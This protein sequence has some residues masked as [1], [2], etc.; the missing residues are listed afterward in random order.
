[1]DAEKRAE[2]LVARYADMV[3]RVGW[4][5]LGNPYD[6]QDICQ[7]VFLKLIEREAVFESE[8]Q[9]KAWVLRVAINE[10]KTLKRSAWFR[11]TVGLEEGEAVWVELPEDSGL[12]AQ[13]ARLPTKYRQVIY[14]HYYEGYQVKEIAGLL[15]QAPALVSTHLARAREK[16]KQ[17]IGGNADEYMA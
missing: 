1:M 6:A 7:N 17:M 14:L 8:E 10:C 13:V 3:A 16:L 5:W 12:F 11:R 15:G 9:E 2:R 4:T